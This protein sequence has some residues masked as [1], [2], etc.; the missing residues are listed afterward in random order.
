[1]ESQGGTFNEALRRWET[2]WRADIAGFAVSELTVIEGG[3]TYNVTN[4]VRQ[5]NRAERR[6]F[7][8][9]EGVAIT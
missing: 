4:L 2:R 1:M 3:T 5:R 6:R 9:I 7:M 8:D